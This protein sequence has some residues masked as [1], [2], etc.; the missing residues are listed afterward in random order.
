MFARLGIKSVGIMGMC[1]GAKAALK[2][3]AAGIVTGPVV[4]V[5]PSFI[6]AEDGDNAIAPVLLLPSID[7]NKDEMKA[8]EDAI[9]KK[10]FAEKCSMVFFD[11]LRHGFLGA[12][13][14][15]PEASD[16]SNPTT[17]NRAAVA[18]KTAMDFFAANM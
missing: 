15:A 8:F 16:Y 14:H 3:Q 13:G 7:E 18:L 9:S 12:R 5:H 11:D 2:A 4:G 17:A 10:P 1:F 6:S